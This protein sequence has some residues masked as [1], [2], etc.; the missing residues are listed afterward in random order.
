MLGYTFPKRWLNTL[1]VSSLR[2][3]VAGENLAVISARKGLAPRQYWGLGSSTT[4]GSFNYSA[5]R[6]ISGGITLKF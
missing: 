1:G 3:Y 4:S 5:L 6:T 2:L